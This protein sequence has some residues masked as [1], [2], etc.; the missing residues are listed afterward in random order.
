[1]NIGQLWAATL[2]KVIRTMY[3]SILMVRYLINMNNFSFN[4]NLLI[5][6]YAFRLMFVVAHILNLSLLMYNSDTVYKILLHRCDRRSGM[7][8]TGRTV[9]T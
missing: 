8:S 2:Y 9:L 7:F 5:L 3:W 6:K 4:R 1:M